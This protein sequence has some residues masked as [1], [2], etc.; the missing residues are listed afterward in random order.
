MKLRTLKIVRRIVSA[1]VVRDLV[2]NSLVSSVIV[3]A[4]FR[5][6]LLRT[7]GFDVNQC[8][9]AAHCFIGSGSLRIMNGAYV[10]YECF[11]DPT[12]GVHIGRNSRFGPRCVVFTATHLIGDSEESRTLRAASM[13]VIAPVHVGSNVWIGANVT[14]LPGVTIGNGCVIGAGAVVTKD[15]TPNALY[16]GV[17]ARRVRE[18]P[19]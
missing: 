6:R 8:V 17:P 2:Q 5:W 15:C 11:I 9:I 13:D 14:I 19:T 18:L 10:S 16:A 4:S 12:G 1:N 3:P 7:L